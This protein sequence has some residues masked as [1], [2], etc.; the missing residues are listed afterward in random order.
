MHRRQLL[1]SAAATLT[2]ALVVGFSFAPAGAADKSMKKE[3]LDAWLAVEGD[4]RIT[5]YSGK[6][7]LGTGVRTALTQMV[8][9]ELDVPMEK[10]VLVM[11]DTATT[12][13]QGQTAGGNDTVN[14]R[15]MQEFL[16]PG[17]KDAEESDLRAEVLRIAGDFHERLGAGPE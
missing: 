10:I 5:I 13:D 4:G 12:I 15:M 14:V 8:A 7:D 17:V 16:V 2:Q 11:G 1:L 9:D 3:A 6:V